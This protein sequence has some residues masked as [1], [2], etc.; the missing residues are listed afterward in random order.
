VRKAREKPVNVEFPPHVCGVCSFCTID[1][2]QVAICWVD[3]PIIM[4][5][6]EINGS[7]TF[8]RGNPIDPYWPV[9]RDFR[10][11]LHA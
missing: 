11:R 6:D 9:C 2:D 10:P 8:T 5:I 4:E 1:E 3:P 7:P